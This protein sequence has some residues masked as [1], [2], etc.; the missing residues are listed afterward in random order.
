MRAGVLD[1]TDCA[2][3]RA[4]ADQV[5]AQQANAHRRQSGAGSSSERIAGIQYWRMRSPIGVPGPTL[6]RYSLSVWLSTRSS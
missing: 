1:E 4:V 5:L 3:R 6:Q 2:R